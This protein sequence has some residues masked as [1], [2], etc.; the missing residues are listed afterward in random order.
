MP[1][2]KIVPNSVQRVVVDVQTL[3]SLQN[4]RLSGRSVGQA[5]NNYI[6]QIIDVVGTLGEILSCTGV[7]GAYSVNAHPSD[8]IGCTAQY[9]AGKGW[10]GCLGLFDTDAE[11][12]GY[13]PN[14][15]NIGAR[16]YVLVGNNTTGISMKVFQ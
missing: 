4:P 13:V 16:A 15:V 10:V 3:L 14:T 5:Q 6:N 8:V 9:H 12:S 2:S 7:A 1:S 11:F